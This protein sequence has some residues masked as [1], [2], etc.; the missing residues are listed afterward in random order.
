MF[1]HS[2]KF[3]QCFILTRVNKSSVILADLL[4][5]SLSVQSKF[6]FF[7]P[8]II[9]QVIV[10][11]IKVSVFFHRKSLSWDLHFSLLYFYV[12]FPRDKVNHIFIHQSHQLISVVNTSL[13]SPVFSGWPISDRHWTITSQLSYT[14]LSLPAGDVGE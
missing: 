9:S 7:S 13:W 2:Y 8:K 12:M 1:T 14:R 6:L 5:K 10:C 3:F 4:A 11:L